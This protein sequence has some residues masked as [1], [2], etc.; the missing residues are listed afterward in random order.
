MRAEKM[1]NRS[2]ETASVLASLTHMRK[3]RPA[4][5]RR[6]DG[7]DL[8]I[9]VSEFRQRLANN[10]RIGGRRRRCSLAAFDLVFAETVKLVRL[11]NG[12]FVPFAFLSEN[13]QQHRL[14]LRF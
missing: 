12:R 11:F 1:W 6:R 9:G 10:F 2:S 5:H 13:V 14:V 3:A 8:L 4:G 7:D